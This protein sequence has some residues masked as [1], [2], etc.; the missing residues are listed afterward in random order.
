MDPYVKI[1]VG[2]YTFRTKTHQEAGKTPQWND[3]FEFKRSTEEYIQ[4]YIFDED[5]SSDDLVCQGSFAL[6]KITSGYTTNFH[7]YL[8][9]EY[10]GAKAAEFLV[11]ISFYPLVSAAPTST[12]SYGQSNSDL[13]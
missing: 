12:A 10:K 13:A 1:V 2:P 7:D 11:D 8:H 4:F 6:S 9:M 5:V 3:V